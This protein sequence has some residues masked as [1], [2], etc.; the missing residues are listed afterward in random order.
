[1]SNSSTASFLCD[2]C[3]HH[4]EEEYNSLESEMM[5]CGRGHCFCNQHVGGSYNEWSPILQEFSNE[6]LFTYFGELLE[7]NWDARRWCYTGDRGYSWK[8]D[9]KRQILP[10]A[11]IPLTLF[12]ITEEEYGQQLKDDCP[13]SICPICQM[14]QIGHTDLMNYMLKKLGVDNMRTVEQEML[15]KFKSYSELQTHI[16]NRKSK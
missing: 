13:I 16:Y 5:E 3:G 14:T 6:D 1:M 10:C 11:S 2:I 8:E 9:E 12:D 7:N 15:K 4:V